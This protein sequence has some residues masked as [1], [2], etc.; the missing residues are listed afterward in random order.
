MALNYM[1]ENEIFEESDEDTWPNILLR[2]IKYLNIPITKEDFVDS[3]GSFNYQA[4][5]SFVQKVVYKWLNEP[6]VR[7]SLYEKGVNIL[8]R[9]EQN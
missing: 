2:M 3:S 7:E 4:R 8:N 6:S 5:D 1:V 9:E